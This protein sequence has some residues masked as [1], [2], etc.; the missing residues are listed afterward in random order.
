MRHANTRSNARSLDRSPVVRRGGAGTARRRIP[1]DRARLST[2]RGLDWGAGD[3]AAE[4]D[5]FGADEPATGPELLDAGFDAF[6]DV[7]AIC[8]GQ[9]DGVR[10]H[11]LARHRDLADD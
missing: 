5:P 10:R 4:Q 3:A 9:S 2:G 1:M 11:V 6:G 7:D 8:L